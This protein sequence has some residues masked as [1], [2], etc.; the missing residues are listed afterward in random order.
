MGWLIFAASAAAYL[1][2]W[3]LT[4]RFRYA[5]TR[6]LSEPLNC[7]PS[8]YHV[9]DNRCRAQ[10]PGSLIDSD[11]EAALYA[12]MLGAIW[13][14]TALACG[15]LAVVMARPRETPAEL[16]AKVARLERE[17]DIRDRN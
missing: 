9:H 14:L 17:L 15:A 12:L 11:G 6:L 4:A 1:T 10:K 5:R 7:E 16:R 8:R 13:P 2:V 3:L